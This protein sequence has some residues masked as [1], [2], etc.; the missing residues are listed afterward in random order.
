MLFLL[1]S[2]SPDSSD[3]PLRSTTVRKQKRASKP[4]QRF[5]ASDWL[6]THIWMMPSPG[7]SGAATLCLHYDKIVIV[8]ISVLCNALKLWKNAWKNVKALQ[9]ILSI[10]ITCCGMCPSF[11]FIFLNQFERALPT[12]HTH[13]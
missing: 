3:S 10:S 4:Q 11:I 2:S 8:H 12:E 5:T 6:H 1:V 7:L 9:R 13:C